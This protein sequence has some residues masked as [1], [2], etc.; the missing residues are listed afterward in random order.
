MFWKGVLKNISKSQ[1]IRTPDRLTLKT[2]RMEIISEIKDDREIYR[3]ELI[4][5]K[6]CKYYVQPFKCYPDYAFCKRVK[7][8]GIRPDFFCADGK[9]R[10]SDEN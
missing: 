2:Q 8:V 7:Y 4:R 3:G 6:D 10:D 1:M 9:R 5:C